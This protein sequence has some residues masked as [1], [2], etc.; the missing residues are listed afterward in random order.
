MRILD[1]YIVTEF[2]K[3]FVL[4]VTALILVA[5]LFELTDEIK[6]YFQHGA[7]VGQM[8]VYFL[9]KIPGYLFYMIPLGILL[10]GM[11]SLFMMARHSEVIAMQASGIDALQIVRPL[12]R[13][14]LI[15]GIVLFL[16]NESVIPWAN[17]HMEDLRK[18]ITGEESEAVIKRDKIWLR[19]RDSITLINKFEQS[20][21]VLEKVT[22][23]TWDENFA[24]RERLCADKAKWWDGHWVFYGVNRT[25][26]TPDGK[27]VVD[28]VP[29]MRS[30]I[31]KPPSEFTQAERLAKEM[32]LL[33]LGA[34]IEK[35]KEEGYPATRYIV[36][37]HNK[38]AFPF[39]CLIMAALSVPFA[40]KANPRG[41]S[42]ALGLA[43]S[44]VVAFSYWIVHTTFIALGHGGYLPPIAAAWAG[45]V[46]FG[47]TSTILILHAG[48]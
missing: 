7:T 17:K 44:I 39:I 42:V 48:T 24:L 46:V 32:N 9:Y 47:L 18:K 33:Q 29:A 1:R 27:F 37:W 8:L 12:L 45:N 40:V 16:L 26:R 13:A 3:V 38:I 34:Y 11:L 23:V 31:K 22:V 28:T 43:F 30:P 10:G 4:C 20:K 21:K 25:A 41:G 19:S 15:A 14:G 5:L 6:L 2:L 36:D 35:L